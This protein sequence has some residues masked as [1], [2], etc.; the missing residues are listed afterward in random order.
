MLK[1]Q[2]IFLIKIPQIE[3]FSYFYDITLKN[4][5]MKKIIIALLLCASFGYAQDCKFKEDKIDPFTKKPCF[6]NK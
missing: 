5:K 1:K 6:K 4:Y 2:S 3:G